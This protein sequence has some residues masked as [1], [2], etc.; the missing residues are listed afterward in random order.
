MNEKKGQK[1]LHKILMSIDEKDESA[2]R[3]ITGCFAYDDFTLTVEYVPEKPGIRP[4][5]LRVEMPLDTTKFPREILSTRSREIAARDFIVRKFD[6]KVESYSIFKRGVKGGRIA[7]DRPGQELLE[8]SAVVVG[9]DSIEIRFIVDLPVKNR[10]V[11]SQTAVEL[12]MKKVPLIVRECFVYENLNSEKLSDWIETNEDADVLRSMLVE[13]GLVAFIADG[14]ILTRHSSTGLEEIVPFTSPEELAVT[15]DLPNR[16]KICG[17]GIPEGITLIIGG[18][19]QGKTTLLRAIERGVYNHISGDG[20]ELAVTVPDAAAIR[21]EEGRKVENVD[22]SPLISQVSDKIDTRH[23]TSRSAFPAT[24]FAANIMEAIEI[25]TSLLLFDDETMVTG[26]V[27]RD[28]RVQALIPKEEEQATPLV[29][30]LPL[31][32]D[33]HRISSIIVGGSGDYFEYADTVI[34]V[35]NYK[36]FAVT[37]EAKRIAREKSSGRVLENTGH[38]S[39]PAERSPI[40]SS[41]E[42]VKMGEEYFPKPRGKGYIQYGDEFI[43]ATKVTQIVNQSQSRAIARGI[44]MVHRLMDGSKSLREAV[45]RVIDRVENVGLDTMSNRHMGDLAS[46]R[47][48]ELAA[49][50]N[51]LKK[52]RIK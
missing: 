32:R 4:S 10:K 42:P 17:M 8:I 48:L 9:D 38:F 13:N 49:A 18:F 41:L 23:F 29:D 39:F 5:R 20:R 33:E 51:R 26:L 52:L 6:S 12:F 37:D 24:S 21:V 43:D 35:R 27:D 22:I 47:A 30:L 3:K 1:D 40:T 2:Y 25:G 44:A 34:A 36:V 50:I 11:H 7:I 15:F 45:Y 46:F 19:S 16:G 31:L 14:S 28:A